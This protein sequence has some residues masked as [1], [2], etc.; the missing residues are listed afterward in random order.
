VHWEVLPVEGVAHLNG[1][2]HRQGHG[3]GARSLK[4]LAFNAGEVL[5]LIVALHEVGLYG[6]EVRL[7]SVPMCVRVCVCLSMK[8]THKLVVGDAGAGYIIEEPVDSTSNSG[9]AD[10]SC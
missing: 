4:D 3:H 10:V 6:G 2:Q 9:S 5:V 7:L 8:G 1:D